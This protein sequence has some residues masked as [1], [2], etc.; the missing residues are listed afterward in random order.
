MNRKYDDSTDGE[1]IIVFRAHHGM[2]MLSM[3]HCLHHLRSLYELL[4]MKFEIRAHLGSF[5]NGSPGFEHIVDPY[6]NLFSGGIPKDP[7]ASC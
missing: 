7:S 6:P 3:C 2:L 5:D 1:S 4:L